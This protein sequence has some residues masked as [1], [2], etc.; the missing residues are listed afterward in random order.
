MT[1]VDVYAISQVLHEAGVWHKID[2]DFICTKKTRIKIPKINKKVAYLAGVVAG[3]G[4][5]NRCKRKEGGYYYRVN[6]V[7]RK[8]FIEHLQVLIRELFRYQ[9]R[10]HR[11]KRKRNCY[12]ININCAAVYFFFIQLGFQSGKKDRLRVPSSIAEDAY[13]FK[14]YMIQEVAYNTILINKRKKLHG[15]IAS[16]IEDIYEDRLKG[17]YELLAFHYEKAEEWEKAAEYYGRAGRKV[18]EI[19][20]EEESK[21]LF[22]KKNFAIEKIY[23]AKP[24]KGL[25]A[26]IFLGFGIFVYFIVYI[27][28]FIGCISN[29]DFS[30]LRIVI[31]G[32]NQ[33]GNN[34]EKSPM[35]LFHHRQRLLSSRLSGDPI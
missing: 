16:A 22:D 13:L 1:G 31:A 20:T 26:K 5:L 7:G 14:H 6:V 8:E 28:V 19:Y 27:G 12:A 34:G 30:P 3:D 21:D 24:K 18:R 11:D 17:L 33:R 9:P 4:N 35:D 29:G 10:I 32:Q 2:E 23:E 15:M 25:F